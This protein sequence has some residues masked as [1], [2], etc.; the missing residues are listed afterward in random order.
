MSGTRL[1]SRTAPAIK[2]AP[3]PLAGACPSAV[4]VSHGSPSVPEGPEAAV[5]ALARRVADRLPGWKIRGATLAAEGRLATALDGLS[6][7]QPLIYPFFM[8]DGWFVRSKLPQRLR[9]IRE[10]EYQVLP[11]LGLDPVLPA[12][13]L[14]ELH[15]AAQR[16]GWPLRETR[17]LLAAHGSP[18]DARPRKAAERVAESIKAAG[19][20]R[21]VH[22]G[23]IDEQ[24]FLAEAARIEGPALCL[25]LFAGRAGHVEVDLPQALASAAF[26]GPLLDPIGLRPGTAQV[27]AAALMRSRM[28]GLDMG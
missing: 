8:A 3:A 6:D 13:C 5:Q 25:P 23:F 22:L 18:T 15:Q 24:P 7:G 26:S 28:S 17:V 12:V 4:I 19:L 27:V 20:F 21:D 2:G 11:P 1:L 10:G 16:E 14:E 9:E